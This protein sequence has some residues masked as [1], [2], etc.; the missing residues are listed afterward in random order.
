MSACEGVGLEV[1]VHKQ[2]EAMIQNLNKNNEGRH[3][4]KKKEGKGMKKRKEQ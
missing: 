4:K 1:V 3:K 2:T